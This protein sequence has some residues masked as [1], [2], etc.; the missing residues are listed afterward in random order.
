M[1]TGPT[2]QPVEET[3]PV[4][5]TTPEG[6]TSL[7]VVDTDMVTYHLDKD[8]NDPRLDNKVNVLPSLNDPDQQ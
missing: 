3:A 6:N 7:R 8:P 2:D 4:E 1:A 5:A